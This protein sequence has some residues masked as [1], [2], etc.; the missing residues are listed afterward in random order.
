MSNTSKRWWNKTTELLDPYPEPKP[1]TYVSNQDS[2]KPKSNWFSGMFQK[3]EF[4]EPKTA[5][6]FLRQEPL[7]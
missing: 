1:Q 4:N 3:Q 6:E 7:R 2:K 5:N